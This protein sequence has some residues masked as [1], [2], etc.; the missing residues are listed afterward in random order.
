MDLFGGWSG[1]F[2]AEHSIRFARGG[3]YEA[4]GG[5][6]KRGLLRRLWECGVESPA[7]GDLSIFIGHE[8]LRDEL[9]QFAD[10]PGVFD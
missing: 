3:Q 5:A 8:G 4:G 1:D 6:C 7:L 2:R 9:G 10:A